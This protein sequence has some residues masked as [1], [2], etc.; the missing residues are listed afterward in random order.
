VESHQSDAPRNATRAREVS[1]A[2]P[3]RPRMCRRSRYCGI[4]KYADG[5]VQRR[6]FHDWCALVDSNHRPPPCEGDALPLSQ[7][8]TPGGEDP[9][10]AQPFRM[11][12]GRDRILLIN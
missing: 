6:E 8:R 9:I 12:Q 4:E 7:A 1:V 2:A 10:L 11:G 3:W 5:K